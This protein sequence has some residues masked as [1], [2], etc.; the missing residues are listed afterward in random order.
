MSALRI[1]DHV[2]A[3][4]P[5][6]AA[7]WAWVLRYAVIRSRCVPFFELSIA[8]DACDAALMLRTM[9]D[10]YVEVISADANGVFCEYAHHRL[11]GRYRYGRAP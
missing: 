3:L 9:C 2:G 7:C 6:D 8:Q 5:E 4:T 10:G 1:A 11:P